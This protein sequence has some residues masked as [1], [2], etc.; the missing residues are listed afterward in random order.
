MAKPGS[1]RTPERIAIGWSPFVLGGAVAAFAADATELMLANL[2][3]GLGCA[4]LL[5]SASRS[6][7]QLLRL[8]PRLVLAV[9]AV[10][11][12]V[13]TALFALDRI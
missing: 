4:V 3:L 8:L 7:W 11:G 13:L 6:T 12:A 9:L 10:D 5:A 1:R 2:L